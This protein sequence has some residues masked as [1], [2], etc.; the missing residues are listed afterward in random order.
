MRRIEDNAVQNVGFAHCK[1]IHAGKIE[2]G[3]HDDHAGNDDL[4]TSR[5]K[6]DNGTTLLKRNGNE[7]LVHAVEHIAL[8]VDVSARFNQFGG[9]VS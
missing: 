1:R 6:A 2:H 4:G 5:I 3:L 7:A 9:D 8:N